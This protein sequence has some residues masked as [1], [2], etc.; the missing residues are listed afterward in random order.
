MKN[1]ITGLAFFT[2]LFTLSCSKTIYSTKQV[3][4]SY[5]TKADVINRFGYPNERIKGNGTEEWLYDGQTIDKQPG[6]DDPNKQRPVAFNTNPVN[7]KETAGAVYVTQLSQY[8][9]FVKYTFDQS[10][11]VLKW[12][13]EGVNLAKKKAKPVNAIF[14]VLGIVG[15]AVIIAGA[16]SLHNLHINY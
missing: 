15:L 2:L 13:A 8:Q 5:K 9:T 3:M 7:E 1:R 10:G 16:I 12:E 11:R 14:L 6:L 4:D